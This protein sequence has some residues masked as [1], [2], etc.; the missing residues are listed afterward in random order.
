[1]HEQMRVCWMTDLEKGIKGFKDILPVLDCSS[2]IEVQACRR[3]PQHQHNT[4]TARAG[5]QSEVLF[6]PR[7]NLFVLPHCLE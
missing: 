1:M 6:P 4:R 2:M 7:V 3:P 5:P